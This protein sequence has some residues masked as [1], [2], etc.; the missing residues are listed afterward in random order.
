MKQYTPV[1]EIKKDLSKDQIDELEL[2]LWDSR[3]LKEPGISIGQMIEFLIT[4]EKSERTFNFTSYPMRGTDEGFDDKW[5]WT[6]WRGTRG[7]SSY[8]EFADALWESCVAVLN[9]HTK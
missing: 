8:K 3:I 4:A 5:W 2:T 6:S 9:K 1:E 7:T